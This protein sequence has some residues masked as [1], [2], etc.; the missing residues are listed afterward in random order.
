MTSLAFMFVDVPEPVWKTSIGNWSSNS[1]AATRSAA[2]AIRSARSGVEEVEL[3]VDPSGGALD[4]GQPADDRDGD[5][6]AGDREVGD[7]LGRL[8]APKL[9]FLLQAHDV[10]SQFRSRAMR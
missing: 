3:G 5:G 6:L 2:A 7:S 10:L 8:A 9:L 1:P 4:L